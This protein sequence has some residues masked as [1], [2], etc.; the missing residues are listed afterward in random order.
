MSAHIILAS[1]STASS[2]IFRAVHSAERR[3]FFLHA[4]VASAIGFGSAFAWS[5][6]VKRIP[7]RQ[8][9]ASEASKGEGERDK[10]LEKQRGKAGKPNIGIDRTR[11]KE[12]YQGASPNKRSC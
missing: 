7:K 9:N 12:T 8:A 6:D 5:N 11:E 2:E 3:Q 10:I 1:P 4:S